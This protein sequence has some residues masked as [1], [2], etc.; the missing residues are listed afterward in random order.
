MAIP[1]QIS[2]SQKGKKVI[3]YGGYIH[4]FSKKRNPTSDISYW[5]CWYYRGKTCNGVLHAQ[6]IN[7]EYFLVKEPT[8]LLHL[9][10]PDLI[11]NYKFRYLLKEEAKKT[12][13]DPQNLIADAK[14]EFTRIQGSFIMDDAA[15]GRVV[16][17]QRGKKNDAKPHKLEDI[18]LSEF[19]L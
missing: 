19:I 12:D 14:N 1:L 13:T 11:N 17:Y 15:C 3:L 4:F 10:D 9:P 2:Y 5:A 8:H 7:G 16:L 18:N 6:E